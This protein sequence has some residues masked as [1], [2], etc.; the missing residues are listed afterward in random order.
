MDIIYT[1]QA[2]Q[3]IAYWEGVNPKIVK[4]INQLLNDI[5]THPF[6]G[7]GKPEP[8]KFERSGYWSRRIDQTHRLVYKVSG[9]KVYIAQCRYHY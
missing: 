7:I 8:L 4:R 9:G 5:K 6:A 2:K 3:D 1:S